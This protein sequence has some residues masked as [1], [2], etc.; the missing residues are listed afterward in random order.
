MTEIL[1]LGI[2]EKGYLPKFETEY[3]AVHANEETKKLVCVLKAEYVPIESF[4]ELFGKLLELVKQ[5]NYHTFIFD[6]RSLRTFHQPSMEW[7]YLDWK[8]E[9]MEYGLTKHRKILPDLAWFVKAVQIAKRG[10]DDK[11]SETARQK[12]QIVYCDSLNEAIE[13]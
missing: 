7:Y 12:L 9:A 10:L 1:D 11:L 2:Q 6:K 5:S 3:A 4:K 13:M 8:Q